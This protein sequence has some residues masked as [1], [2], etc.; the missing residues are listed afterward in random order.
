MILKKYLVNTLEEAEELI[1]RDLGPNAVILTM[2]HFKY[3]GLKTLFFSDNMEVVAAVDENDLRLY[4]EKKEPAAA[5]GPEAI[6]P[7]V[8]AIRETP[9]EQKEEAIYTLRKNDSEI[10]K[11]S[12][13]NEIDPVREWES[14]MQTIQE[15]D[16]SDKAQASAGLEEP[17]QYEAS[18]IPGTYLDPRFNRKIE[19]QAYHQGK[20]DLA[21]TA[22]AMRTLKIEPSSTMS[23]SH[24]PAMET[25]LENFTR[26]SKELMDNFAFALESRPREANANNIAVPPSI[27]EEIVLEIKEGN[28]LIEKAY[29]ERQNQIVQTLTAK[30]VAPSFVEAIL[31]RLEARLGKELILKGV[32][33]QQLLSSLRKE[34]AGLINTS[35]PILI[36]KGMTTIVAFVGPSGSGKTTS[37]AKI[38]LQYM[39]GLEKKVAVIGFGLNQNQIG[40]QEHLQALCAKLF[41]PLAFAKDKQEIEQ[42]L[43]SYQDFDLILI[44]TP[45]LNKSDSEGIKELA[46][47][48]QAIQNLQVQLT[49]NAYIK[50]A[51]ALAY[52]NAFKSLNPEA[53]IL[54]RTDETDSLG[55]IVNIC[56]MKG[57]S[58]SYLTNGPRIPSD[59]QIADPGHI[60][61]KII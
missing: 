53:L 61:A 32:Q 33:D 40:A 31:K 49:L 58:I 43:K 29:S 42:A 16:A 36:L 1:N 57:I 38:A 21:A 30:G 20:A 4:Q 44:D 28:N 9:A 19:T 11:I 37:L 39:E 13:D 5:K 24:L 6:S 50:D 60:A 55:M 51:D 35:G 54:T 2:R 22:E 3:K 18:N 17:A 25:S 8:T 27:N 46:R 26:V 7:S 47:N 34:L 48:F 14:S 12:G 41:L 52:L 45:G 59:L 10:K 56:Q 15:P 23:K